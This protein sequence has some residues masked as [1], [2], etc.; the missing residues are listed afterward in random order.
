ME[1]L[2]KDI[3]LIDSLVTLLAGDLR[4]L[5]LL[6]AVM[7]CLGVFAQMKTFNEYIYKL[8]PYKW[9]KSCLTAVNTRENEEKHQ[10]QLE[11]LFTISMWCLERLLPGH[12]GLDEYKFEGE[13]E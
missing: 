4:S 11:D 13:V 10:D 3:I 8:S 9:I 1:T 12:S 5:D 7:E 6:Y 2:Q